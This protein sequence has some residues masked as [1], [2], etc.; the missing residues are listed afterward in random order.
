MFCSNCGKEASGKFCANCGAPL[1]EAAAP[2][3]AS[4]RALVVDNL[5]EKVLWEGKPS[6]ITDKAKT[7]AHLNGIT[8]RITNQR[9]IIEQGIIG[10][11]RNEI[12]LS[13]V[14]DYKVNQ[15]FA[16][17]VQKIGDIEIVSTDSSSPIFVMQ[18]VENPTEVKEILRKAVLEY[19]KTM[20]V[21]FRE[22][23]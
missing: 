10:K 22:M 14:R 2:I 11:K 8:Y 7:A 21:S 15:S 20:N 18:N 9:L 3:S 13:R 17:R 19:R 5:G 23:V 6:S 12:E 4:S 1:G 16:E